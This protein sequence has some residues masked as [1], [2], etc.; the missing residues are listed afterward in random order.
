MGGPLDAAAVAAADPTGQLRETLG[1]A[2]HLRDALW[3]VE[4]A[5]ISR[6]GSSGLVVAGMGG[7]A[8][9]G[10]LARA[11]LGDRARA[12][13]V[14]A[15]DYALPGWVDG[16]WTVLLSSYSGSREETLAGWVAAP[17]G[18]ARRIVCSTGGPLVERAREAGVPVIPVPAGF[19][20]RA[21]VGYATVVALEVA[22][23]AGVAPS[24]AT[25]VEAAAEAIAPLAGAWG[26]DAATDA[27]PKVLARALLGRVP[28]V[29]G[30]G[31]TVAAAYRLKCQVNEN[32]NRPAFWS[33]LPEADHN[34]IEGWG[35]DVPLTPIFLEDPVDTDPRTLRRF[36]LT[37]E[38]VGGAVR[39]PTTGASRTERL[40]RLVHLGD[41]ASI[42]LAVLEGV[43]P[44]A[45]PALQRLKA[46]L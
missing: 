39:I 36:D 7:S 29:Y 23:L 31:L 9:G 41:L 38:I 40:L 27:E 21:A 28:V 16:D 17:A 13:F 33:E 18:G 3:R 1:L 14:L 5:G 6:G 37:A 11:A 20:P 45:I 25:E 8:V 15:R 4:S 30:A 24:L 46:A 34:E 12:P 32:A 43:D 26:P 10:A 2:E 19:Q 44:V 22:A 42:Y 35:S